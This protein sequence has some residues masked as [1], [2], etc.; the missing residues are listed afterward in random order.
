MLAAQDILG[1]DRAEPR[2]LHQL[3]SRAVDVRAAVDDDD[4]FAGGGKHGADRGPAQSRMQRQDLLRRRHLRPGIARRH[5]RVG[6]ALGL[7]PEPDDHGALRLPSDR[8]RRLVGH[9]DDV[10]RFDRPRPARA[11]GTR[12]D[13]SPD[14][15]TSSCPVNDRGPA[16]RAGSRGPSRA[17]REQATRRP[18]AHGGRG[19]PPW[20]PTRYAP[21]L[22]F[23]SRDS[24][25][26]R[27]VPALLAH[28][29]RPLRALAA[30]AGLERDLGRRLVG[31][32]RALFS[33]RGPALRDGHGSVGR[34][35]QK[36][37][38]IDSAI[39]SCAEVLLEVVTARYCL[40]HD[41]ASHLAI[42]PHRAA[43]PTDR[44]YGPGI[45]RARH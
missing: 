2:E 6:P 28:V 35:I 17:P 37:E 15:S 5:E 33:L 9:L 26:A 20:R 30:G 1:V 24:L 21:R 11:S 25:F 31:V 38:Q 10:G 18:R 44:P 34:G 29:V 42:R 23:P 40:D 27:V 22:R 14:S 19:R 45:R 39:R 8:D 43:P 36:T 32:A 3:F 13:N 7:Q 16:R 12:C 4:G 41:L